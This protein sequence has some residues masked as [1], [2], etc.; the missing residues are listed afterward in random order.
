[1]HVRQL[2]A[3]S[4]SLSLLVSL[5]AVPPA[6]AQHD[7]GG[8]TAV[9]E[10]GAPPSAPSGTAAT[11]AP[12]PLLDGTGTWHH[13]ITTKSAL[14][15]KYFDQALRMVFAFNH[16]EGRRSFEEAARQ[17]PDCAIAWWGVA[18][19][20]GPN[21]NLPMDDAAG[22][23][24]YEAVQ[25]AVALKAKASPAER[26]YIDA[27]SMRY[28]GDSAADRK[29]LDRAY[30]DAMRGLAKRYPDDLDAATLFAESMMDL[31]PWSL[32]THDGQPQPGTT[33]IVETLERVLAKNPNHPGANHYYI[34]AVEASLHPEKALAAAD[35]VAKTMPNAG[36]IVHM[37]SHIYARLGRYHDASEQNAKAIAVDEAYIQQYDVKGIYP[38]MYYTHNIQFRWSALC[39][40]GRSAEAL[41]IADKLGQ[42]VPPEAG[43]QMQMAE[44]LLPTRWYTLAR[45]G[46]WDELLAQRAPDMRLRL[47]KGM[48]HYTHGL[49]LAAKAR[50]GEAQV[51]QD[52]VSIIAATISPDAVA[53]IQPARPVLKV[54]AM[55][56]A[57][58]IAARQGNTDDAVTRLREAVAAQDALSY[59]EPPPFYYPVRQSLGAVLLTAGRVGDAETV[60]RDDLARNPHNGWSLYG[61]QQCLHARNAAAEAAAVQKQFKQAWARADVK[62]T[63]SSF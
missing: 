42:L 11:A 10:P 28:S 13:A 1:M 53:G 29:A 48:W 21:I 35:R 9:T 44:F 3:L 56:L 5:A 23:A 43:L 27:L 47:T 33:E 2:Y 36:H 59:D 14:A 46:H 58:E 62:L 26:D 8:A 19:T 60:Y 49:A 32:W 22:R 40:E 20:L 63:A 39:M 37:P 16:E 41:Q 55:A 51:D 7:H 31:R 30:A 18:L 15:Q 25:K 4:A 54:A 38:M 50:F 12:A 6:V 34:H 52:S 24:A 61:L 57:G 45:F 17:D